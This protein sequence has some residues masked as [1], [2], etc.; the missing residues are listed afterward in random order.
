MARFAHLCRSMQVSDIRCV[1][2]AAV[3]DATNGPDFIAGAARLGMEGGRSV[4]S[5]L[6]SLLPTEPQAVEL[7]EGTVA[8]NI[9]RFDPAVDWQA[10]VASSSGSEALSG[11]FAVRVMKCWWPAVVQRRCSCWHTSR[12]ILY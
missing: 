11:C 6:T 4:S 1:A 5:T 9:A 7:L 8:E 12:C 3:R 2:T 10:R